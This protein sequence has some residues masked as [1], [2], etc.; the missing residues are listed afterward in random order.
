MRV[1]IKESLGPCPPFIGPRIIVRKGKHVVPH[2]GLEG[3]WTAEISEKQHRWFD[4]TPTGHV[5]SAA[6]YPGL[7]TPGKKLF[8]GSGQVPLSPPSPP[9]ISLSS[10]LPSVQKVRCIP[11]W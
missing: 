3:R 8:R 2:R 4:V 9:L 7:W 10:S 1:E 11:P 6:R 5:G